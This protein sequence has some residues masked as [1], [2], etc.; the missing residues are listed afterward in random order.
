MSTGRNMTFSLVSSVSETC[1]VYT[2]TLC[3]WHIRSLRWR[4]CYLIWLFYFDSQ[5]LDDGCDATQHLNA[6]LFDIF[7]S[8]CMCRRAALVWR[9][10][11]TRLLLLLTDEM[12][13]PHPTLVL[14]NIEKKITRSFSISFSELLA[15]QVRVLKREWCYQFLFGDIYIN[16]HLGHNYINLYNLYIRRQFRSDHAPVGFHS[17]NV[18]PHQGD[19][20]VLC[21]CG[22]EITPVELF[23]LINAKGLIAFVRLL[24]LR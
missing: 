15:S 23:G 6:F 14:F 3:D 10:I 19:L 22:A 13:G 5:K 16:H 18:V 4:V 24:F 8:Q 11:I 21:V 17:R 12:R 7:P 20:C 2:T 9:D 1:R